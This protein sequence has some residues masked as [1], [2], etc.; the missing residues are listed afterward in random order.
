[1]SCRKEFALYNR[2]IL[3]FLA[4][5]AIVRNTANLRE[6]TMEL[7]WDRLNAIFLPRQDILDGIKRCAGK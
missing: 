1:M 4:G 5:G 3:D 7:D 2:Q 6:I